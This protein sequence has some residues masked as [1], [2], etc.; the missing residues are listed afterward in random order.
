MKT[1]EIKKLT[2]K[3]ITDYLIQ[4]IDDYIDCYF[5]A[6]PKKESLPG[7]HIV[8]L[9]LGFMSALKIHGYA[10][11]EILECVKKAT[12]VIKKDL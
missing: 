2:P 6:F 5:K 3:K 11:Y 4:A 9:N 1:K 10:E 7:Q 8:A 12:E